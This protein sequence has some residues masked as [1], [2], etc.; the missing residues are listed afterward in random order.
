MLKR[1]RVSDYF[2]ACFDASVRL[3]D[4]IVHI[5][6]PMQMIDAASVPTKV[7]NDAGFIRTK[8]LTK[9]DFKHYMLTISTLP[10]AGVPLTVS[11]AES[12]ARKTTTMP[13]FAIN[14]A[15]NFLL[16][17]MTPPTLR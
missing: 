3:K 5:K 6:V 1:N 13:H 10:S 14:A 4:G 8:Y 9:R 17:A 2:D 15:N 16:T 7:I 11:I 12:A